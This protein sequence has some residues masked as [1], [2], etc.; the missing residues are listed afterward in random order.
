MN[1]S[2]AEICRKGANTTNSRY[3]K[4]VRS[5][6]AKKTKEVL[7][8]KYGPDYFINLQ[9]QGLEARLKKARERKLAII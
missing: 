9:K 7:L 2:H 4:E 3:S 6:W 5:A 1:L 8:N